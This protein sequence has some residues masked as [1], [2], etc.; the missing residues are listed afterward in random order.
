MRI[1][2]TCACIIVLS[3]TVVAAGEEQSVSVR[4]G[5]QQMEDD[6]NL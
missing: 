6:D 2:I 1:S 5:V 4:E 3:N